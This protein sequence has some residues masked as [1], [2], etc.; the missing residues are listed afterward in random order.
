MGLLKRG[1]TYYFRRRIPADLRRLFA[2]RK[3]IWR[4][5]RTKDRKSANNLSIIVEHSIEATFT[6]MRKTMEIET[7]ARQFT[8]SRLNSIEDKRTADDC[9]PELAEWLTLTPEELGQRLKA[10]QHELVQGD[11]SMASIYAEYAKDLRGAMIE[12]GTGDGS[13]NLDRADPLA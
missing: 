5:L 3:E 12:F 1:D 10:N 13:A 7:L 8:A 4:S 11:G 6:R 9:H 2:G